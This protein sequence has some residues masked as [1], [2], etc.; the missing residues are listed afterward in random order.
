MHQK[1][2]KRV[3]VTGLGMATALGLEVM[4]NWEKALAGVSGVDRI[5]KTMLAGAASSPVAAV[6]AINEMSWG[7]IAEAFPE[8]AAS[9]DERRTMF[10]LWAAKE[11]LSDARLINSDLRRERFGAVIAAG[12]GVN[13]L[14]DIARWHRDGKFNLSGFSKEYHHSSGDSIIRNNSHRAAAAIAARFSIFGPNATITTAC[15]SATQAIGTA[16]RMIQNGEADVIATGGA[17]SMIN[18]IGL[19]FFVLLQAACTGSENVTQLCRPFDRKRSGLVMGEGAGIVILEDY[20]HAKERGAKIYAEVAG[21]ASSMDAYQVTAPIP[22][23]SGAEAAMRSA[24][25]DSGLGTDSIDYINAHGTSTKLNDEA[26]TAA[27]IRVFKERALDVAISSSKSMIGHLL[28]ASGG[29]EFIFTVLSVV[30]DEI[31]PTINLT[32]PDPKCGLD[33]VPLVKRRKTVRAAISN[34]FGFGGQNASIIV[35]KISD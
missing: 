28:A 29:P 12:L 9:L 5:D 35:K 18:P 23:G 7:R 32:H 26:E 1:A 34:S 14:E 21:Y 27:I 11:A 31:H 25:I 2:A 20:G 4:G 17:D 16:F 22:D 3:V 30:N 15:A 10:A 13:R 6:A 24:L 19:V 8:E 33:Y